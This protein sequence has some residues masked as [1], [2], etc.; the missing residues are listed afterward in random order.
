MLQRLV[1]Y[2][3]RVPLLNRQEKNDGKKMELKTNHG[4]RNNIIPKLL[5]MENHIST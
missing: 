3:I 1:S 2:S 4:K 5:R